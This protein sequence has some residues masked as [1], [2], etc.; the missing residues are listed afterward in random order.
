M[1]TK[2]PSECKDMVEIRKEIDLIDE[3]VIKLL[4]RRFQYVKAASRFKT[5]ESGVKAPD[6]LKAMLLQRRKWAES[7][8]LSPDA[9]EKMY[10]HLVDYFISEE[11]K[12]WKSNN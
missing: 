1:N 12:H 2:T 6:R 4:G 10:Q 5:S 7:V 11:L 3:E 9:I 8:G